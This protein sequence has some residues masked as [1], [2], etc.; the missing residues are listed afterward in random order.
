MNKFGAIKSKIE[1]TLVSTYGKESFKSNLQGFKKR[2]LGDKNLAEAYYLYDELS[3]QKGL[4][5]E[6]ASVYVNESFEKLNDIITN[7]KEK[8][9]ELS[10]WVNELLD[11]SVENN[12]VD[13]DNVIYEKSLTKLEAVVESKLKI[14]RTLSETKIEDVIKES[15]NLPLSTMLKIASNTFNKEYENISES[16]K[17]ELKG[18]LSM[19]KEDIT[20]E[21]TELKESV[22]GKLKSTLTESTDTELTEKVNNTISKINESKNDLVSLYKLKQLHSGL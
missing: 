7:N 20:K 10:K 19:T 6:V 3:S 15:V 2:I 14:Q 5:K 21:M 8:I 4:S 1:K 9:E 17:E 13:I 11:E 12:Y 16:E 18:L 22:I